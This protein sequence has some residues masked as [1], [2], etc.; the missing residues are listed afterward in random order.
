MKAPKIILTILTIALTLSSIS[1]IPSYALTE[2]KLI[3][4]GRYETAVKISQKA[5]SSSSNVVLVND[6]SL[7]DALSATPF[8]KAKGAPIL[9]TE[10]DKLDDRTEKEIKRLG[11]K[12]I[13]L[14][15]GT[16]VLNKDIEN[17]LK[18]NGLNVERINGKDR[19]ETSLILA[20]KLKDIKD[21]KEVAV[22][23]GEKGLSD[24]VSVGA[25]AAQNK[26]PI[27][28]SSPK[29]GVEAFDKFI[30]DEKVIKAYVIG[31]TNSVSRAVEKSLPNAERVSGKDRNETNAKVIEKFYTD[32]N[33]S[34]LYVT[35]DGSKNENQ[36]I[37]SLAVGVL[38]AKNE[39]P[40]VLV[41]NKL[42]TKQ[43][44]I[45]STKKLNTITQVGG[46]GNEEAFDEIKSL[47]EKTVFEAKTVEEL[48]DMIN[49]ASPNDII[50]FKPKE[51]TVNEAFRM[52]TNKPIT[53]NIKGDC[54]KTLTVDMPNG[55]VNNYATLVN[56]IVRNIGEGG[57]NNHDTI[58][59]L[60]VRDKNGRVI[61]N[62]RNSDIDT[63]MILASA[64][65]TKL[66]ND[67][68]IG[69]L[70]D[71]SSNSDITNNG[72]I[73]KKVNQVEDL[74]AKVD[75]IEKAIDSISQKVNKIQD[76][77]DKLGFLKKFLS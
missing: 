34:N 24:A 62:T 75:S 57:F 6:N 68:Y 33:L 71:N 25:P 16:A 9:L 74:E 31:G 2:E 73:D 18:G 65:D 10:S 28:L 13:Y 60:S 43:R 19:Y 45:L 49:I 63:L 36:L 3:G 22:V 76:I 8:A 58:T 29:D 51:N 72:T 39:S 38:A 21:I 12:D 40:V 11:A 23:N 41:G 27:I 1:I 69:K 77:L 14:I 64:N 5:Y 66:I 52:V 44:D 53:V 15:G 61:E 26:M 48:T 30:R 4:N 47:Q 50:N 35:K 32:T 56:V 17:K 7:A 37:D 67:G 42:N 46:N 70:I 55:E 20:N 54:S 59:I